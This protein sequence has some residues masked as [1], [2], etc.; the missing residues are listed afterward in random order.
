MYLLLSFQI[1][2]DPVFDAGN[3]MAVLI[4]EFSRTGR[5]RLSIEFYRWMM[6]AALHPPGSTDKDI[7]KVNQEINFLTRYTIGLHYFKKVTNFI[8]PSHREG[9]YN[10]C[11][12]EMREMQGTIAPSSRSEFDFYRKKVAAF[13]YAEM[14]RSERFAWLT[15]T[16]A[17]CMT[18]RSIEDLKIRIPIEH[19]SMQENR[20]KKQ[21]ETALIEILAW[22][23]E[24]I[25][26]ADNLHL[27]DVT[28]VRLRTLFRSVAVPNR[29]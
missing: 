22:A 11:Y 16:I 10:D 9:F 27:N 23:L 19:I 15:L 5:P 24:A 29:A 21:H 7:G 12:Q 18:N 1:V 14:T 8:R 28:N 6:N 13:Y 25:A 26:K 20:A 3:W 17:M 4:D 2:R